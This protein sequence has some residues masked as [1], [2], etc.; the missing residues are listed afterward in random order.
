VARSNIAVGDETPSGIT[1]AVARRWP[2]SAPRRITGGDDLGAALAE[3]VGRALWVVV[4][5]PHRHHWMGELVASIVRA[6]PDAVVIDTGW[7]G[8]AA[9]EPAVQVL[10]HG[11]S[12]ASGE[13][14]VSL[15]AP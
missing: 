14:V 13:A 10:T 6:R 15:L 8:W 4:R 5:D 7:P 9:P 12:W 2:G 3:A 1:T 11:A